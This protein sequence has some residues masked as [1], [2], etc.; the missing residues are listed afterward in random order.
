[1]HKITYNARRLDMLVGFAEVE[2][3]PER[4]LMPGQMEALYAEGTNGGLFAN[5]AAFTND[6]ESVILISMDLLSFTPKFAAAVR[7]GVSAKT[8]VPVKN[9]LV[10]AIHTHTGTQSD[11]FI[12]LCPANP[13]IA[14]NNINAAIKAATLAWERRTEASVGALRFYNTKYNFCRDWVGEDG[15]VRTNP[16]LREH[17]EYRLRPAGIADNSVNVMK[18]TDTDGKIRCVLVNYANH[19]DCYIGERTKF[20]ADYVGYMRRA[21]KAEYGQ[22]VIVLFFL[23]PSG[24]VNCIDFKNF[25]HRDYYMRGSGL[26]APQLIGEGLAAD[27]ISQD[28]RTYYKD[29]NAKIQARHETIYVEKRYAPIEKVEWAKSVEDKLDTLTSQERAYAINYLYP[30]DRSVKTVDLEIQT[31]QIGP[32]AIVGIPGEVYSE[33]GHRIKAISPYS[34]TFICSLANGTRGYICTDKILDTAAYPAQPSKCNSCTG[35]GTADA[36]VKSAVGMLEEMNE[37][38]AK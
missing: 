31:I 16:G 33:I 32:W 22:D 24:D 27:I 37:A 10:C 28:P 34:H 5:A 21:L 14:Q 20:C 12:W 38:A 2:F 17:P 6:G 11:E 8:G 29:D 26:N 15:N 7:E 19:P 36:I 23:G 4:G 1:M 13:E 25:T 30:E 9:I 3:T 18:V 35:K